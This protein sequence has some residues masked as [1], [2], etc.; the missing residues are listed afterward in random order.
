MGRKKP[1]HKKGCDKWSQPSVVELSALQV[2]GDG[3]A[4]VG[5]TQFFKQVS[6]VIFD[7]IG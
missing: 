7:G 6:D 5:D 4:T 1:T 3:L 2:Q